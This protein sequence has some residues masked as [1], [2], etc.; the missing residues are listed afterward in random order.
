MDWGPSYTLDGR[1]VRDYL[2]NAEAKYEHGAFRI[3]LPKEIPWAAEN[4][5]LRIQIY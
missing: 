5:Q 3:R 2:N 4:I 1:T